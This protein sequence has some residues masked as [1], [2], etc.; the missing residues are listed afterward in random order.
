MKKKF[1][2]AGALIAASMMAATYV[3]ADK[4]K[5]S[6]SQDTSNKVLVKVNG[7]EYSK[8]EINDKIKS[9]FNDQLPDNKKSIDDFN[10]QQK[11]ELIKNVVISNLLLEEA[12][13]AGIPKTSEFK[14]ELAERT[15]DI[16]RKIYIDSLI[17]KNV[18]DAK[19]KEEYK[20]LAKE[21]SD[22]EEIRAKHILVE[23]EEKAKEISEKLN[24]GESFDDLA[25]Q[26][27]IDGSKDKGG[28]L[29]YFAKG[30]M[31]QV[32]EDT[33]FALKVGEVSKP[34]K[35]DFGWHIIKLEDKRKMR[36]PS[37][38]ETKSRLQNT[39]AQKYLQDYVAS[40]LNNSKFEIVK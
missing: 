21:L 26:N 25:K 2:F 7:K 32:F 18:T 6:S 23:K 19:I 12:E 27:S 13:K 39:L 14:K 33:A 8:A 36:V 22:K 29:G 3:Q 31:V 20:N 28:D 30:Q 4:N 37:F 34:V 38:E 11:D 15:K 40:L 5:N 17:K 24:K 35:S 9:I 16:E 10:D 1:I